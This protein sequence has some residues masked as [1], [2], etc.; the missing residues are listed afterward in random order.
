MVEGK[1]GATYSS[2][3]GRHFDIEDVHTD[4]QAELS[5]DGATNY[6]PL[7]NSTPW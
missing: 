2:D 6:T 3:I 1:H 4:F 5:N 7:S